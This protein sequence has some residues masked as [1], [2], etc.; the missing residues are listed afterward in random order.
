M[1]GAD[2][3]KMGLTKREDKENIYV[4]CVDL[5][6]PYTEGG[7]VVFRIKRMSK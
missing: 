1:A 4:Q 5:W 7:T 2:L 3:V 6:K